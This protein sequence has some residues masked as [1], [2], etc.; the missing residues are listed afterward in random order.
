[1]FGARPLGI[2][3]CLSTCR[4]TDPNQRIAQLE[5]ELQAQRDARSAEQAATSGAWLTTAAARQHFHDPADAARFVAA[6]NVTTPADADHLV[7]ELAAS[8][9][10]RMSVAATGERRAQGDG[11]ELPPRAR[12]P[13]PGSSLTCDKDF[14]ETSG[15]S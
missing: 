14:R 9:P 5:T 6:D 12:I 11:L 10:Q 8:K 15:R 1:M 7:R 13:C 3:D 4:M 2:T